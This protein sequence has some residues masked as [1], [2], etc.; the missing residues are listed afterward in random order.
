MS[1][2]P[3]DSVCEIFPESVFSI[4]FLVEVHI[5][6]AVKQYNNLIFFLYLPQHLIRIHFHLGFVLESSVIWFLSF[7]ICPS[8]TTIYLRIH[9]CSPSAS[10]KPATAY[11]LPS[12]PLVTK[13]WCHKLKCTELMLCIRVYV[14]FFTFTPLKNATEYTV[15]SLFPFYR[16]GKCN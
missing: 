12:L 14:K 2:S 6:A 16:D 7:R 3:I 5:Q 15:L 1:A 10:S 8:F 13:S 9:C 11:V 4:S